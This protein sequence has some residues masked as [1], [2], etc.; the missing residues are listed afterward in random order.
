VDREI[1]TLALPALGSLIAQ[2]LFLLIDSAIVGHLGTAPLAGLSLAS[3]LVLLVVGLCVFLAF[4]TTTTVARRIGAGQLNAALQA[5]VDGIWLALGLGVLLAAAL[6]GLAPWATRALGGTGD[7]AANAVSYLHWAAPG[8]P[9]MLVVLAATGV[10]RGL[11][12]LKTPLVVAVVGAVVNAGLNYALV[13]GA[14]M[15][16]AGSALGTTI[17]QWGSA[18]WLATLVALG[19]RRSGA[20]LRP[21]QGG[22]LTAA[23]DGTP[24]FLR[25]VALRLAILATVMVATRLG[26]VTLAGH[27]IVNSLWG[28][29]AF[30][31]DALAIA[32]Q[33]LIAQAVGASDTDEI[34]RAVLRRCV[35]WGLVCGA[36]LGLALAATGWWLTTLFTSALDVRESSALALVVVGLL[37]PVSAYAFMLDGVLMGAGDG[38][39]LAGIGFANLAVYLPFLLAVARWAPTGTTELAWLWAAF[40]G[41]FMGARALTTGLRVRGSTWLASTGQLPTN[42]VQE[43][44]S[45]TA[46]SA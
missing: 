30:A 2:P 42:S 12:D 44:D 21:A 31:L 43:I 10:L 3:N 32:S 11:K 5:G 1:F 29:L 17:V 13:Y 28:F 40:A 46:G 26:A 16:I 39:F 22:V 35:T 41:V 7:V 36:V 6:F 24:L 14:G 19:A 9:A 27:Q 25:T 8:V 34:A 45:S 23:R 33:T 15:G 18:I 4:A 20:I 38:R 37:T